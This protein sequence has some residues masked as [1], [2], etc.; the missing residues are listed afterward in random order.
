LTLKVAAGLATAPA[1]R[2]EMVTATVPL[3]PWAG[4]TVIMTAAVERPTAVVTDEGDADTEKSGGGGPAEDDPPPHDAHS[5]ATQAKAIT[6]R[7][8]PI[9][10]A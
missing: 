6:L 9:A 2:P 3:N 4:V 10:Q 1:G 8:V 7:A 5:S